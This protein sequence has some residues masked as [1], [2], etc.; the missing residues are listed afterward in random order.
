[1]KA[2]VSDDILVAGRQTGAERALDVKPSP[3]FSPSDGR[4]DDP[5]LC[6]VTIGSCGNAAGQEDGEDVV[7]SFL[8]PSEQPVLADER[9]VAESVVDFGVVVFE[10]GRHQ[11]VLSLERGKTAHG[12]EQEECWTE[13]HVA[14]KR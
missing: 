5:A 8:I 3:S 1:L 9:H 7:S 11:E 12:S 6:A 13:R 2:K 10:V 4:R 14:N